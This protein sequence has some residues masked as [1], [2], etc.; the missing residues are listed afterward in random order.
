MLT[1]IFVAI[2]KGS[3]GNIRIVFFIFTGYLPNVFVLA[4]SNVHKS[5]QLC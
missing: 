1:Q 3:Q 5:V 4:L 2:T